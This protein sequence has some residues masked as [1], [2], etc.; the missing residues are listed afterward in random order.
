MVRCGLKTLDK[1]EEVEERER[2]IKAER[3]AVKA[4][5]TLVHG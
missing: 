1:L 3:A 5:T 4:A 2:Q